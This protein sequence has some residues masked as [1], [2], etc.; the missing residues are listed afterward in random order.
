MEQNCKSQSVSQT[1]SS[2][3]SITAYNDELDYLV[4]VQE[5]EV[6]MPS[7]WRQLYG[8]VEECPTSGKLHFQG[9]LN[10]SQIRMGRLKKDLPTAHLEPCFAGAESLKKYVMKEE[11]SVGEKREIKNDRYYSLVDSLDL[12]VEVYIN[13]CNEDENILATEDFGFWYLTNLVIWDKKFLV[14]LYSQP[15]SIRAWKK[16]GKTLIQKYKFSKRQA[17]EV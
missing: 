14:Q 3:W 6:D 16:F 2:W 11:T 4:K 15:Q 10:T 9:A 5:G 12:L 8:G 13:D 7:Y 17:E 1:R